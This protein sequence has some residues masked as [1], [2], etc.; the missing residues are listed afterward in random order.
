MG[1]TREMSDPYRPSAHSGTGTS[2]PQLEQ[3]ELE[4]HSLLLG[5]GPTVQICRTL[6]IK[7]LLPPG[8]S[9][10]GPGARGGPL[11]GTALLT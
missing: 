7:V 8:G 9:Q 11:G 5:P 2:Q 4:Q 6:R 3:Q 10:W 1:G